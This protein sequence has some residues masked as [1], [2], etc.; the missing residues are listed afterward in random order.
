MFPRDVVKDN[1]ICMAMTN[2]I[3]CTSSTSDEQTSSSN[4][5]LLPLLVEKFAISDLACSEIMQLYSTKDKFS[6]SGANV[7]C[8]AET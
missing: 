5:R 2:R 1:A 6:S 8:K 3:A 7:K 4:V